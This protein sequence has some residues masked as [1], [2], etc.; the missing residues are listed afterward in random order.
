[1]TIRE[2]YNWAL[3]NDAVDLEIGLNIPDADNGGYMYTQPTKTPKISYYD[4][5]GETCKEV[6]LDCLEP[7][8]DF[9]E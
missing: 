1:M 7:L 6:E 8:Y 2:L 5:D 3:E 4:V 9:D